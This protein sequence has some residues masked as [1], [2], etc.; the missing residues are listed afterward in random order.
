MFRGL[1]RTF[2][3]RFKGVQGVLGTVQMRFKGFQDVLGELLL[4]VQAVARRFSE[5][6]G[7]FRGCHDVPRALH[8]TV[9]KNSSNRH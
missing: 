6:L 7:D 2:Q 4:E 3:W 9:E 8:C 5:V 1:L